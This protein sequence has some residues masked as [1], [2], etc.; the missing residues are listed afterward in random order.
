MQY[1]VPTRIADAMLVSSSVPETDYGEW[2]SG[3]VYAVDQFVVR[4]TT[5]SV[6]RRIV[7]GNSPTPP[8]SDAINWVRVGPTNRWSMFDQ[9]VGTKTTAAAPS[10][11]EDA[12]ITVKLKPGL[13][14]GL[15]LLD[16][17]VDGLTVQMVNAG[18]VVYSRVLDPLGSLEDVDNWFDYF[19]DAI[20]RRRLLVIRDLPPYENAELT[21]TFRGRGSI[22]V[23]SCIVGRLF[24]LGRVLVNTSFGITDYSKK[25]RDDFGNVTLV[26]RAFNKRMTL[27]LLL[28]TAS[29]NVAANRLTNVRATPVVWIASPNDES[30]VVY[31]FYR[32]WSITIPGRVKSTCSLEIEG[33]V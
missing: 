10:A 31:G 33:L 25:D 16:L 13:I 12:V 3:A 6:Y 30:L 14:R 19:F 22:S 27:P 9:V 20:K 5:H 32:D 7:A 26:E 21:L 17:D 2:F 24:N 15:A 23:G 1:L 29:I 28:D 8:E 18:S 4:S 11:T